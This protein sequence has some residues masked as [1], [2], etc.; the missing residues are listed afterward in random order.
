VKLL[1]AVSTSHMKLKR[2]SPARWIINR[3]LKDKN[4]TDKECRSERK[5]KFLSDLLL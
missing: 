1:P 3:S 5:T 2:S 4:H